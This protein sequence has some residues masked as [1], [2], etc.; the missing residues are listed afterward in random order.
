[1]VVEI[2]AFILT[3]LK[4]KENVHLLE[5]HVGNCFFGS[6]CEAVGAVLLCSDQ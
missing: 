3:F 6:D 4:E 2:T 1:M 5:K